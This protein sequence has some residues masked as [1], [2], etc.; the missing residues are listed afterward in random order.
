MSPNPVTLQNLGWQTISLFVGMLFFCFLPFV[1]KGV[2][3][4]SQVL[5]LVGTGALIGVCF[6]DLL[7]D[8]YEIGGGTSLA[9]AVAIGLVYSLIHLSHSRH[10]SHTENYHLEHFHIGKNYAIFLFSIMSH[11]FSSGMLLALSNHYTSRISWSVFWALVT[12]K[13]YESLTFSS[14]L[15]NEKRSKRSISTI[16]LLYCLSLPAGVLLTIL[17][18]DE[19]SEK[20]AMVISSVAVGSLLGCLVFDFLLPSLKHLRKEKRQIGWMILGLVLTRIMLI[21]A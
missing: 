1:F 15:I 3:K 17:L 14:I 18:R 2:Q 21:H 13:G 10:H 12:H 7:P 16:I 11:C 8:V 5:F 9:I 19:L 4:Y 6:F 20:I